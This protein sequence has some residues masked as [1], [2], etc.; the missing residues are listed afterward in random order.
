MIMKNQATWQTC[1]K[2]MIL[3]SWKMWALFHRWRRT[4]LTDPRFATTVVEYQQD[5]LPKS[6]KIITFND[7]IVKEWCKAKYGLWS[8]A[9]SHVHSGTWVPKALKNV[10]LQFIK[11]TLHAL[12]C[13]HGRYVHS[14][15]YVSVL[16]EYIHQEL[17]ISVQSISFE[18]ARTVRHSHSLAHIQIWLKT[19]EIPNS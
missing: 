15:L 1:Q 12:K 8:Y 9:L 3:N 13:E 17:L 6:L 5:Q 4:A 16:L 19:Q 11:P 18:L 10:L 2:L 14:F 7:G